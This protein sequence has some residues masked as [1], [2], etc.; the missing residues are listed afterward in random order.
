MLAKLSENLIFSRNLNRAVLS[1]TLKRVH[2]EIAQVK[3]LIFKPIDI[4]FT[5]RGNTRNRR[6]LFLHNIYS[7][8]NV[9]AL[10]F[11]T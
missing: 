1:T 3:V 7:C 11:E 10:S 2:L 6:E 9:T 5:K 8:H 4:N